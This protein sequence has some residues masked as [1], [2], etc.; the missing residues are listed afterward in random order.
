M[1]FIKLIFYGPNL[2]TKSKFESETHNRSII[3]IK[4]FN[5]LPI[6][7]W[8]TNKFEKSFGNA[9]WSQRRN[10]HLDKKLAL[11]SAAF[12]HHRQIKNEKNESSQ[13]S[14]TGP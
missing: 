11:K 6:I 10:Q 8:W 7:I 4:I 1:K 5:Y 12:V 2:F 3:F 13:I 9:I 14:A